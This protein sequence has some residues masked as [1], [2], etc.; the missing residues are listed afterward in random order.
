MLTFAAVIQEW[1]AVFDHL[2]EDLVH[3]PPSQGRVVV[4]IADE[5]LLLR[6]GF[7]RGVAATVF[8]IPQDP[9]QLSQR[10]PLCDRV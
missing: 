9:Y 8:D 5:L 2:G 4:E 10:M 1:S 6:K 3:R 7:I